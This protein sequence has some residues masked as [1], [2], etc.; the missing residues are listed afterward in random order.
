MKVRE[1]KSAYLIRNKVDLF[2]SQHPDGLTVVCEDFNPTSTGIT[3]QQTK[4]S[5]GLS[6][7]IFNQGYWESGMV[8]V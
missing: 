5:T 2:L 3:E 4:N 1:N 7:L 6:Q 8:P